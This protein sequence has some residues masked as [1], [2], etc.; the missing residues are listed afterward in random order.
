M[1]CRSMEGLGKQGI[2]LLGGN[3]SDCVDSNRSGEQRPGRG[4]SL[5]SRM[6][7]KVGAES[8]RILW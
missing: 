4:V 2:Q 1:L 3:D 7:R 5:K 6:L 8:L